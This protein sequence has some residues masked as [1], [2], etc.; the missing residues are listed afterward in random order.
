MTKKI[1]PEEEYENPNDFYIK[2]EAE[3][4]DL[5]SGMKKTQE[6]LTSILLSLSKAHISNKDRILDIGCGTGFS[7]SYL[8]SLGYK[9]VVGIDP[10]IEMINIAKRKKLNVKVGGFLDLGA[11][12]F[13]KNSF[14]LIISV[15]S[16]QWVISNK[17]ELE[18]KNIIK[19]IGKDVFNLL[20][21]KGAFAIQFYPGNELVFDVVASA[22]ERCDFNVRKF[23]YNE[24]SIK[25]KKFILI[26]NK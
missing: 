6:E 15:S 9:N 8:K 14:D 2:K 26:L 18:I 17:K 21:E 11:L 7:I 22:F 4:Y 16:L 10:A 25:K 5:S 20:S 24:A 12:A 1:T 3:R 19:K 23:I 13:Q